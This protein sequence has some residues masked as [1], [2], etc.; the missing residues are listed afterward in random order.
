M[1][2]FE[3]LGNRVN[4]SQTYLC[5]G[6]DPVWEKIPKHIPRS[7]YGL[8][9]FLSEIVSKTKDYAAVF[10]PNFAYFESLGFSGMEVLSELIKIIPEDIPVIGDAKRGDIMHSSELYAKAVFEKLNCDAITVNP[11][12]GRE[13]L[14][15]FFDFSE[16]GVFVL[17]LSSNP[18]ANDFQLPDLFLKVGRKVCE[19]NIYGN[20]GLVVGATRPESIVELRKIC[21]KI[22]FLIPGIGVQ[23]GN[24]EETIISADDGTKIPYILSASRSILY[25]SSKEDYAIQAAN[26]A[27]DLR[28]KINL[29]RSSL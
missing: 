8:F 23:R 28:D 13:A 9:N 5:I 20:A 12:L 7:K 4:Y 10:K 14:S 18:G 17:C 11:Y 24:I 1:S 27:K 3:K 26:V 22:P 15:P 25:A 6:L 19:W 21:G 16:K 29:C 2:F